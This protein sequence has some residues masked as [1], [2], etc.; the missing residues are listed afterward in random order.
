M[1]TRNLGNYLATLGKMPDYE[2]VFSQAKQ[3]IT[4]QKALLDALPSQF[5]NQCTVGRYTTEGFLLIYTDNGTIAARLRTLIPSIRRAMN[6]TEFTINDIKISV[7]P[8]LYFR[9]TQS[10]PKTVRLLSQTAI[11]HLDRL[12]AALPAGSPLRSSLR[13]LLMNRQGR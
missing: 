2:R 11:T 7:Q 5:R 13:T 3:L 10:S 12:F 8:H 9:N 1:S 4:V 6:K